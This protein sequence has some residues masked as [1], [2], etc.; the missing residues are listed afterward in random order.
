MT[1]VY[2]RQEQPVASK[3]VRPVE[4][5]AFAP[6][7]VRD[8]KV[9]R[10]R[11]YLLLAFSDALAISL[12]F[13]T[14]NFLVSLAAPAPIEHGFLMLGVILPLFAIQA[15]TNGTYG[16]ATLDNAHLGA[17]RAARALMIAGGIV[18]LIAYMLKASGEL[19]RGVFAIGFAA[20]FLLLI[21]ARML[22]KP[23]IAHMLGGTAHT[24]IVIRDR[25]NY[26]THGAEIVLDA[27]DIGFN[28]TT[29]DPHAYHNL[30]NITACSDRLV[31]A[32]DLNRARDWAPVLRTLAVDGEILT[33]VRDEV[34]AIGM[35]EFGERHTLVIN[36]GPMTLS[37]RA[38]KR[39][40]DMVFSTVALFVLTLPLLAVMIA[41]RWESSG[42]VFFRQERIGRGNRIFRIFKFRSMYHH[43]ADVHAER[44]TQVN[45]SRVTRVGNFIRRTS[46]DE[47]P[48]LINVLK[49]EMSIVGP[50]PHAL[51]AKAA[52]LLYWDVDAR[53]RQRHAIK[54]GMTG[55]AQVRGFRGN[56]HQIEDLTNRLQADLEYV[57]NWSLRNDIAIIVQTMKVMLHTN[58]Y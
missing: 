41:I 44:L 42:P 28:P 38:I 58:A 18:L 47:L 30:A 50:R 22:L 39:A 16:A 2:N 36:Y 6:L 37:S 54:P 35:R 19:S 52:N 27:D 15:G 51:A 40:F 12:S 26:N 11:C 32:C 10:F 46:I 4:D 14:A 49:G 3:F 7:L 53:Y 13:C 21:L 55:L 34:S 43:T 17:S 48:Q 29:N 57:A 9:S 5:E 24:T 45:D 56:T 20:S 33:D 1:Y 25:V 31:V 8:R 23:H